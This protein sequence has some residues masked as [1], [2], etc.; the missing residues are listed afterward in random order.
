MNKRLILLFTG[1][2][3]TLQALAAGGGDIPMKP[4]SINVN[5]R[6]A[7]QRGA[8]YFVNYCMGCHSVKY[9]TY[10]RMAKD[11]GITEEQ[12]KNNL[13]FIWHGKK[14]VSNYMKST[15]S[16]AQGKAMFESAPPDLSLIARSRTPKWI[17]NYLHSF[18]EDQSRPFGMNNLFFK[19]VNM[20]H[21]M[22][23]L[24]GLQRAEF[25]DIVVDGV[26][27]KKFV[28]FTPV[29]SSPGRLHENPEKNAEL[30][31]NVVKDLVTFLTYVG[32]PNQME[33]KSTGFWVILF[34]IIFTV[35]S[36]FLKKEYWKDVH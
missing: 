22:L 15:M 34:L 20:P 8:K 29:K 18:Y 12:V 1:L 33:R 2:V 7:L 10:K 19:G 17:Y 11:I 9:S 5:D 6:G 14:K 25:K 26:K 4:V 16:K 28:K 24:Q 13:V 32:E 30:Y 21:A 3:V 35:I 27:K 31:D 36:Y 23:E